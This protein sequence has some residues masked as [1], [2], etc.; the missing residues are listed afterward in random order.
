MPYNTINTDV[1]DSLA[2]MPSGMTFAQ[3]ARAAELNASKRRKAAREAEDEVPELAPV[4]LGA[5]KFTKRHRGKGSQ[6]KTLDELTE[7]E[8]PP[9]NAQLASSHTIASLTPQDDRLRDQYHRGANTTPT[10]TPGE[11][12]LPPHLRYSP[13]RSDLSNDLC[14]KAITTSQSFNDNYAHWSPDMA[15]QAG[16]GRFGYGTASST[17]VSSHP[18]SRQ[19]SAVA[20]QAGPQDFNPSESGMLRQSHKDNYFPKNHSGI[21]GQSNRQGSSPEGTQNRAGKENDYSSVHSVGYGTY[22]NP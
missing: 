3:K 5:L 7:E 16:Y 1:Q 19:S 14:H 17:P 21:Y 15:R 9:S 10:V 4:S 8:D 22:E 20:R 13:S 11:A 6:A 12:I 18:P 2:N